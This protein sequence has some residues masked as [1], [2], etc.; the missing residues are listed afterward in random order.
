MA[1]TT[2]ER[3]RA[4]PVRSKKRSW[5]FPLNIYQT[6]VGRKWV[7]A[8][9]GIGLIGFVVAHM[10]GNLHVY[11]GPARMH[12]Y[13]ESLRTL[14][15]GIVPKGFIL[16]LLRLGL[17]LMFGLHLHSAITLRNFSGQSSNSATLVGGAKK[18]AGGRDHIAANYAS[19]TMRWT[20]PIIAL[21][22]VSYT[23]LTLPTSDLV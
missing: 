5:P 7:M 20:G 15:G 17:I 16:W 8:L 23:H 22:P 21:F 19:R 14:A 2:N 12:E 4:N 3:Y 11:E 18:Y 10:V 13:A 1:Q 6:A 9:T